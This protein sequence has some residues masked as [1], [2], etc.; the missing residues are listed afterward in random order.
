[1]S[2]SSEKPKQERK[3]TLV[4]FKER[5]YRRIQK[6]SIKKLRSIQSLL[7]QKYFKGPRVQSVISREG[8]DKI[9]ADL[10][11]VGDLLNDAAKIVNVG[12]SAIPPELL[13]EIQK[14]FDDLRDHL[15]T[16]YC[17]C[18]PATWR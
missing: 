3:A 10:C 4:R 11:Y 8:V 14:C 13:R 5:E 6:D 7:K 9:M 12:V 2:S 15:V 18:N 17:R 16:Q 1:M